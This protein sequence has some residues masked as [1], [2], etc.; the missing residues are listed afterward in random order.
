[1]QRRGYAARQSDVVRS[2]IAQD[3]NFHDESDTGV[4]GA[5]SMTAVLQAIFAL[6][7]LYPANDAASQD[8]RLEHVPRAKAVP[9]S[10]LDPALPPVPLDAWLRK[11]IGTSA[12]Y[13]WTEGAC[14]GPR[15][16]DNAPVRVCAIVLAS[17]ADLAV[18]VSVQVAERG[19]DEEKDR[20]LNPRLHDVFIDRGNDSLTVDRLSD[21]VRFL[22]APIAQWPKRDV[23]LQKG[24]V[25]CSPE[26]PVPGDEV[27]CSVTLENPSQTAVHARLFVDILPSPERA[28]AEIVKL[29][30][31]TWMK[32]HV[33]FDWPRD[34]GA[35]VTLGVELNDR[36]PYRRVREDGR[37]TIGARSAAEAV[38]GLI[39]P[40][41]NGD[42]E[43]L[44]MVRGAFAEPVRVF[45]IPVD[46]SISRLVV[47]V[48]NAPGVDAT[49][50]RPG[51]AA[52]TAIDRDVRLAGVRQVELGRPR[53]RA[54][55]S[56]PSMRRN[57]ASGGLN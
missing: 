3:R 50:F 5:F 11:A 46:G 56:T 8:A 22:S 23:T 43:P 1:M 53:S 40:S 36:S 42:L 38:L 30:P 18:T 24:S 31:R 10:A 47:S 14:A 28:S 32:L 25:R 6:F 4:D 29:A 45:E 21:L 44:L 39:E 33:T 37:P 54:E 27:I 16:R 20:T 9:A 26:E 49:L 57:P 7:L 55:R 52:V 19:P 35:T 17:T 34:E 15:D 12:R 41:T 13:E 2:G 48:E 51:G